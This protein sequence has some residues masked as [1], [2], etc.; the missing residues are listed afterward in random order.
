MRQGKL[1]MSL[2]FPERYRSVGKVEFINN[3]VRP[4]TAIQKVFD[5]TPVFTTQGFKVMKSGSERQTK[6][7]ELGNYAGLDMK[8]VYKTET[9]YLG[10][11]YM[12]QKLSNLHYNP[13]NMYHFSGADTLGLTH[14]G[15]PSV[16]Y[17]ESKVFVS[18]QSSSTKEIEF[19][20][21][22]GVATKESGEPIVYHTMEP[23]EEKLMKV[24][25]L[26]IGEMRGHSRR[27]EMIKG[28]VEKLQIESEGKAIT[29]RVSAILKGSRP[30]TFSYTATAAV[31]QS[32]MTSKWNLHLTCER[33]SRKIC[34]D[35]SIRI[36]PFSIWKLNDIRSE[37]PVFRFHNSLGYGHECESKVVI[38]GYAKTS[39]KQKQLARETPEAK[40]FGR[41][42]SLGTPMIELSKLAEIVRRQ[43]TVLDVYDYKISYVNV[44]RQVSRVSRKVLDA[45]ELVLLPYH[46]SK[47]SY[48]SS[49]VSRLPISSIGV[50]SAGFGYGSENWE[51]EVRTTLHP[52]RSSIDVE[53]TNVTRPGQEYKFRDI[54]LPYPLTYLYPKTLVSYVTNPLAMTVKAITGKPIYP[55]CTLEGKHITTFDNRTTKANMDDCFH[56]LSG[57]CSKAMSYG[58]LVRPLESSSSYSHESKKEVKVFIGKTEFTMKPEGE[59]VAVKVNGSPIRMMTEKKTIKG[60][61]GHIDAKI[62]MS[63]DKVVILES[64]KINVLFDGK[65]IKVEGSNLLKNKL[66]GLCGD[67]NNKMVG[68]VPS[69]RQCLL[70]SPKLEVASYRVSLPSK[71]CSPLPGNLMAELKKETEMCIKLSNLPNGGISASSSLGYESLSGMGGS[72]CMEH[73]HE[74]HELVS[75]NN[76]LCFSKIPLLTCKRQCHSVGM[77]EK[78]IG[79]TCM[80]EYDR[81]TQHIAEKVRRG[82][83]VPEL[84]NLPTT[85]T[86]MRSMPVDCKPNTAYGSSLI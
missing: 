9:P 2:K 59:D 47:D 81:K 30:R 58:V 5:L 12:L 35:G 62:S 83:T 36:P 31:G 76:K 19:A 57:D 27:Q 20:L 86:K 42:L 66:C 24:V 55:V 14:T 40:E 52:I 48:S 70:S 43:S 32:G 60:V 28:M 3:K 51:M 13:L 74:M 80:P 69:P 82:E 71:Q 44:G 46:V 79:F 84:R 49:G 37:D 54:P 18:P 8:L 78:R 65:R 17:H 56:L 16:R 11:G 22:F 26:P 25:S 41:L 67:S 1:S 33:T 73:R 85:F 72:G 53:I 64:S 75:E 10:T 45:L 29:V 61:A 63:K 4:Y 7:Y 77:R 38:N 39:E 68:D 15:L 23:S 34:I 6:D 21:D 50:G